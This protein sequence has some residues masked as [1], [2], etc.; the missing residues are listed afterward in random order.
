MAADGKQER[1][2]KPG[3]PG[4]WREIIFGGGLFVA[5]FSVSAETLRDWW[6]DDRTEMCEQAHET[7]RDDLLNREL[8]AA[9][10]AAYLERQYA[11]AMSCGPGDKR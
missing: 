7:M 5:I 9:A 6:D 11:I 1:R 8:S 3:A 2:R 10:R 4:L